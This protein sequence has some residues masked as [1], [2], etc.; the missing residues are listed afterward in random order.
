M[1]LKMIIYQFCEQMLRL[2]MQ[3]ML[4]PICPKLSNTWEDVMRFHTFKL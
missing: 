4:I 1:H 2:F 3:K